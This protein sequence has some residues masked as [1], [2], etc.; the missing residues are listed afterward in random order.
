MS[1]KIYRIPHAE[2]YQSGYHAGRRGCT[3]SDNPYETDS[4]EARSWT[5][6]LL[7]GRAKRLTLVHSI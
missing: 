3:S 2:A 6:G 4:P 5:K 1:A 7:K